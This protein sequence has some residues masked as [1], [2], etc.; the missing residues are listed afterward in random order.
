VTYDL[1]LQ[2]GTLLDPAQAILARKD[3]AFARGRVSAI[4]DAIPAEQAREC[5]DC[6]GLFVSP[7][8]IDLH[9]HVF[10]GVSHYGIPPD[11][12]CIA[13]GVTT[14]VDAG[15]AGADTFAGLRRYVLEPSQTRLCAFLNIASQGM[16]S[17]EIGELEDIRWASVPK[18]LA[19]VEAHRDLIV[20]LKVRLTRGHVVSEASGMRPL[21]IAREAADT[22]GLPLMVHPQ[23]AWCDS[24]DD[25]LAVLKEGD[26]LTHAFHGH[27]PHTVL[28]TTDEV[29]PAVRAARERG[30]IFDLGHGVG[31]FYWDI[32]ERAAAQ[33]FL[34][35]VISSD[36]HVYNIAGPVFDLATTM[37]KFLYLGLPLEDIVSRVTVAP[38]GIIRHEA[39]LGSLAIGAPGDAVVFD[40]QRGA[41]AFHD[42]G[43]Q[44]RTGRQ[45]IVTRHVVRAGQLYRPQHY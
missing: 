34:P 18:V 13:H 24:L 3:I 22:A 11:P 4:A 26:I 15:S 30:V 14:A 40:V 32:A 27:A 36:L 31:S 28:D 33:D 25:I 20:G 12:H 43:G 6:R 21:H 10:A 16:I 8:W 44:I 1:L 45:R 23:A 37:S 17:I 7:G 9:V 39:G 41:F 5:L 38:A 2:G 19:C 35:D 42:S 29:R